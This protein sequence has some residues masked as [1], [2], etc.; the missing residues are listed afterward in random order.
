MKVLGGVLRIFGLAF[1]LVL[2]LGLL[3]L[4]LLVISGDQHNLR[5]PVAPLEGSRLTYSL[6]GGSLYALLA[7]A[8]AA[9]KN[10][11]GGLALLGW[12]IAVPALLAATPLRA[13]FTFANPDQ[14]VCGLYIFAGSLV[15]LGGAW[16]QWRA[17][18]QPPPTA[19]I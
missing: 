17:S 7:L 5:F 12:S 11:W 18:H 6:L 8:L 4:A 14:A 2:A 3:A 16:L 10:R 9:R 1:H 13:S 15:A 19:T